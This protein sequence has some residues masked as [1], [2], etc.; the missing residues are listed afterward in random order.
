[1]KARGCPN[2]SIGDK[3][4]KRFE[5]ESC[6][7]LLTFG[8]TGDLTSGVLLR[9]LLRTA[10][11]LEFCFYLD[12]RLASGFCRLADPGARLLLSLLARMLSLEFS[13]CEADSKFE[14][15]G[16]IDGS[17]EGVDGFLL[18][19]AAAGDSSCGVLPSLII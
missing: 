9:K 1:M 5:G 3:G 19:P 4:F 6:S 2:D 13:R 14:K 17:S 7:W 15:V 16:S 11:R 8:S 12:S 18:L 10:G